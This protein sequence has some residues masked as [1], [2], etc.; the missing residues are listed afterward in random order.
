MELRHLRYF[1]AVA[2]TLHFG[3]A[4]AALHIAQP[5]LSHQIKLLEAELKT[6]LLHRTKRRVELTDAGRLFVEE[7]RDILARA[8]RA[9]MIARRAGRATEGRLRVGVGYC[10]DQSRISEAVSTFNA[11]HPA[12]RVEL[13]TMAVPLQLDA[14]RG[15]TLDVGFVRPPI[16]NSGL[17][18]ERLMTEPLVA[19]LSTNH[20]LAGKRSL[21]LSVLSEDSFILPPREIVPVYH[22]IVL[23][24]CREAGF[25]PDSPHEADHLHMLLAMVGGGSG[26]AL[27][28][29]FA[30]RL[31]PPRVVF[32]PLNPPS[33]R[34][35]LS[36]AWRRDN[37]SRVLLEFLKVVRE[38]LADGRV[39]SARQ[40]N[41]V[42]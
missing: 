40:R 32:V 39:P 27:V 37:A 26:V 42:N 15:Q 38:R 29:A 21:P 17:A 22:D 5:S 9:A 4:A 36:V 2:E 31:K 6:A 16:T 3:Q 13:Q 33:A 10:M 41:A 8:D 28:P 35:Y 18:S 19:A 25:V 23:K 1:V 12:I 34:L 11:R 14:I 20:R 7:A 30:R 24:A